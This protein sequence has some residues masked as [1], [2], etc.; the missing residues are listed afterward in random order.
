MKLITNDEF[1]MALRD[2]NNKKVMNSASHRYKSLLGVEVENCK[3]DGLLRALQKYDNT[4]GMQFSTF[5]YENVKRKC[6]AAAM[7]VKKRKTNELIYIQH[8]IKNYTKHDSMLISDLILSLNEKDNKL[9]SDRFI[10]S[11]TL[12]EISL[13]YGVTLQAIHQR[14]NTLKKKI[15]RILT[16]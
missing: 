4:R 15:K 11:K 8:T 2:S 12:L 5:L 1:T 14:L 13:E 16:Q 3:T 10:Y 9:F 7:K 6:Y